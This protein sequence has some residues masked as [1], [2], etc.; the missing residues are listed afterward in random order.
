[1]QISEAD[2]SHFLAKLLRIFLHRPLHSQGCIGNAIEKT[3]SHCSKLSSLLCG[4]GK[5]AGKKS[6]IVGEPKADRD[7]LNV[8]KQSFKLLTLN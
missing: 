6:P 7:N 5:E 4:G 3:A 2:S 8:L 1:M